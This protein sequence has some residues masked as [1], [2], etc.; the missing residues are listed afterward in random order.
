MNCE[1]INPYSSDPR[2]KTEQVK[3]MFDNI[4]PAYDFMNRAMTFGIDRIWRRKAV[5]MVAKRSPRRILD[6]ATGTGDL[7]MLLARRIEGSEVTGIDLSEGMIE[8]GRKKIAEAGLSHRISMQ[9]G[10]CLQMPWGDDTFDAITVAYGV[11]NFE[12]LLRG[13]REML[14]VL[15][16]GRDRAV[17]SEQPHCQA[18]VQTLHAV[19]HPDRRTNGVERCKSLRLS[20]GEHSRGS[21]AKRNDRTD[22]TGR[23]QRGGIPIADIR[24]LLHLHRNQ[25]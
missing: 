2:S 15:R 25:A 16:P 23:L 11:R 10:D 18:D 13:Y 20:S 21:P 14:R 4:A 12:N 5:D 22:G 17:D 9:C 7:A 3:T 1:S 8:I 6:V 24:H 19:D